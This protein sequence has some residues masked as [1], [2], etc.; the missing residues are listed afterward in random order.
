MIDLHV[1]SI[2][3]DGE[4]TPEELID[5][6]IEKGITTLAITDHDTIEVLEKGLEYSRNKKI[7]FIPGVEINAKNRSGQMHILGLGLKT[8]LSI[9][10]E[11][12]NVL[13]ESRDNRNLKFIEKLNE[14]GFE[15][16][17][18]E[19]QEISG[20]D[21]TGKPH[22]AKVFLNKG[23][24]NDEKEM[25]SKYFDT[26]EFKKIKNFSYQ[27]EEVIEMI[28]KT[29]GIPVLAH[30]QTLKLSDS[31]LENKIIEL[32]QFGLQGIECFHSEQTREEMQKYC[33][34]AE[35]YNLILT[36]GSDY[37]GQIIKPQIELGTGINGNIVNDREAEIEKNILE[38]IK[39]KYD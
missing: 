21:I 13:K 7:N 33:E 32:M 15:I 19:L 5:E 17:L 36:K 10:R 29:G 22:F 31:E 11:K 30:P 12:L 4:K 23:Y 3:S 24:I 9:L 39:L 28:L 1:H 26:E 16:S 18:E 35:K 8:D 20:S 6:S 14:L 34:L 38:K 25:F 27:P 37:H 2:G